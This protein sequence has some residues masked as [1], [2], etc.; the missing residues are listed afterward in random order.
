MDLFLMRNV[1]LYPIIHGDLKPHNIL[2]TPDLKGVLLDFSLASHP[3]QAK[4]E[5]EGTPRYMPP[6]RYA[7]KSPSPQTDIFGLTLTFFEMLTLKPLIR[8]KTYVENFAKLLSKKYLEEIK[9]QNFFQ[10]LQEFLLKGL[11]SRP[12]DRFPNI[13]EME[14]ALREC[15]KA[16]GLS[17]TSVELQQA[18]QKLAKI[19]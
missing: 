6:E 5:V 3:D 13:K 7:G 10:A 15:Q 14:E 16:M 12:E 19:S 2:V 1:F 18:Y 4:G 11:A 9:E 8:E 17:W